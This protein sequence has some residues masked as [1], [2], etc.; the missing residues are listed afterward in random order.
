[1]QLVPSL[2]LPRIFLRQSLGCRFNFLYWQFIHCICRDLRDDSLH[3]SFNRDGKF[4]PIS[5]ASVSIEPEPAPALTVPVPYAKSL[6]VALLFAGAATTVE[7]LPAFYNPA[8]M[9]PQEQRQKFDYIVHACS[10]YSS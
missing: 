7:N 8:S 1:M 2:C 5:V 9:P 6:V 3:N 4:F 10:T